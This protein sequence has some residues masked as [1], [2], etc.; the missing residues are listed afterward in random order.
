MFKNNVLKY[1]DSK[2]NL[3]LNF[4]F[5]NIINCKLRYYLTNR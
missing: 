4:K 2:N 1:I 3:I 5:L